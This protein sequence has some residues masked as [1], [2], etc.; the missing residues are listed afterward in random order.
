VAA[1]YQVEGRLRAHW[2][3]PVLGRSVDLVIYGML[4]AEWQALR[5]A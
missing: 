5:A 3:R 4:R 1:G 2:F